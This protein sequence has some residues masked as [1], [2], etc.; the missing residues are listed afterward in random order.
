MGFRYANNSFLGQ[1]RLKTDQS[2]NLKEEQ[3][4][5]KI[6]TSLTH[7]WPLLPFGTPFGFLVITV[8]I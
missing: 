1:E 4:T 3:T 6:M 8:G 2:Q 7:Y 5:D